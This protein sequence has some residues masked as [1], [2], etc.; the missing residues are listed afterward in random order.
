MEIPKSDSKKF[1]LNNAFAVK[2]NNWKLIISIMRMRNE[3][4]M[5]GVDWFLNQLITYSTSYIYS[6]G[7]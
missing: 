4:E 1:V 5:N 6:G 3:W 2:L 7:F